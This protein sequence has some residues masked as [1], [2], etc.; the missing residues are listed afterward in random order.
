M[1]ALQNAVRRHKSAT[2]VRAFNDF[3]LVIMTRKRLKQ[4]LQRTLRTPCQYCQGEGL[5]KSPQTICYEILEQA[6][7]LSREGEG[8]GSRQAMLRV[9]PDVAKALRGPERDVLNEIEDYLG[10]VD[11]NSDSGVH[12]EQFDF[13]FV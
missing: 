5:L 13:A 11:V 4:S 8:E 1:T 10:S 2:K 7:R 6:R 12:Q 9:N 3:G